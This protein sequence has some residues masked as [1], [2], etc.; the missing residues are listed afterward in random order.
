MFAEFPDDLALLAF[1][2][3][4]KKFVA[5]ALASRTNPPILNAT[6]SDWRLFEQALQK[7][8]VQVEQL[9]TPQP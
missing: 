5:V 9:C 3:S 4:D 2:P 8:G 6:D 1:A 7:H